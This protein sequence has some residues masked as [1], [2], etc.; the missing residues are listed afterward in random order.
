MLP[1]SEG[2]N[3]RRWFDSHK[4]GDCVAERGSGSASDPVPLSK[5]SKVWFALEERERERET[6]EHSPTRA[7]EEIKNSSSGIP[8]FDTAEVKRG[9]EE[10]RDSKRANVAR[11]GKRN[12]RES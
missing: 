5:I 10:G 8:L 2:K 6:T 7:Q 9:E 1:H 11:K 4:V 3:S 12:R